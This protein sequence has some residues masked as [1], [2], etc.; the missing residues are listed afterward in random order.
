MLSYGILGKAGWSMLTFA[1]L[2][3]WLFQVPEAIG[4][5]VDFLGATQQTSGIVVALR[6]TS[7]S[8]NDQ[9]VTKA[10]FSYKVNEHEYTSYSYS[11]R[12]LAEGST[13]EVEY[14]TAKPHL[15]RIVGASRSLM[16]WGVLFLLVLPAVAL[17]LLFFAMKNAQTIWRLAAYGRLTE[18][19]LKKVEPTNMIVNDERVMRYI[20]EFHDGDGKPR[21]CSN[22]THDGE[23]YTDGATEKI[24]YLTADPAV[25]LP[26]DALPGNK[27]ANLYGEP[28]INYQLT[29]FDDIP[30]V[31]IIL[32][33]ALFVIMRLL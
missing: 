18:G 16:G 6:D 24:L 8:V 2:F 26:F 4:E 1:S 17:I 13:V 21:A 30:I 10:I 7:A 23:K 20:F 25:A 12:S 32:N 19:R 33:V 27:K 14:R 3:I 5:V 31:F 22:S 9:A 28:D 11:T 15:A 29:L